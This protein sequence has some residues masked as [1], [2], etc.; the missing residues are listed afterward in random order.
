MPLLFPASHALDIASKTI[1]NYKQPSNTLI[2]RFSLDKG[3]INTR[4]R[5]LGQVQTPK[6]RTTDIF[7]TNFLGS[8]D[9]RA[10]R[11]VFPIG[12][13]SPEIGA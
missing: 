8:S 5:I 3:T 11:E 2:E 4:I 7:T 1:T 13:R 12:F 10:S 9:I 6:F